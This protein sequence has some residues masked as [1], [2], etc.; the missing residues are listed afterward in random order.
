MLVA[1]GS[2]KPKM[3][4]THNTGL[5]IVLKDGR[6]MKINANVVQQIAASI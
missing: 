2:E 6:V 1:F 5:D 3:T 4:E